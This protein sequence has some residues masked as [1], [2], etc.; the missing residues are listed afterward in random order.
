MPEVGEEKKKI[1]IKRYFCDDSL[2][3]VK[4]SGEICKNAVI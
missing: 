4:L 1:K 2:F 3:C